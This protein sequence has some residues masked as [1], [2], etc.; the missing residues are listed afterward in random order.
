[1][2]IFNPDYLITMVKFDTESRRKTSGTE[3]HNSREVPIHK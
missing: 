2:T 3:N 1:M